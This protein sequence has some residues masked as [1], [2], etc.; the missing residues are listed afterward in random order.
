M[1]LIC[2]LTDHKNKRIYF[3]WTCVKQGS[4]TLIQL[5]QGERPNV[6]IIRLSTKDT[7]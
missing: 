6:Q 5:L 2:F 1:W 3:Q 4:S 7:E